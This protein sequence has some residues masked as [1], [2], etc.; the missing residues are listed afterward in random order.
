MTESQQEALARRAFQVPKDLKDVRGVDSDPLPHARGAIAQLEL[1]LGPAPL[2]LVQQ[3]EL[4]L[5]RWVQSHTHIY[6]LAARRAAPRVT[7][8]GPNKRIS[9]RA[10]TTT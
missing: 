7:N 3:R 1:G 10:L 8:D 2:L 6:H 4:F 5:E 9:P